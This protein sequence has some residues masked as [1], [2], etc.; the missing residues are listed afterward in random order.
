[1]R[2][3]G[4]AEKILATGPLKSEDSP[5]RVR[6]LLHKTYIFDSV[7][8]KLVWEHPYYPQYYIPRSA[9]QNATLTDPVTSDS[10][11]TVYSISVKGS[12]TKNAAVLLEKGPLEGYLRLDFQ[13][14]DGW[15]EEDDPIYVHPND[16]YKRIDIRRSSRPIRIEVDGAVIAEANWAMHLYETGLPV[17]FYL[18][19]TSVDWSLLEPSGTR[20]VCPYKGQAQYFNIIAN[21]KLYRDLVWW[22]QTTPL[23]AMAVQN[24]VSLKPHP[25]VFIPKLMDH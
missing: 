12:E 24:M 2:L 7:S 25:N 3:A 6:V 10:G 17:R 15:F 19:R 13:A 1:M 8:T 18:P 9:L 21:G 5:R 4:I 22:Y 11:Y 16:P 14:M 20:S 23:D